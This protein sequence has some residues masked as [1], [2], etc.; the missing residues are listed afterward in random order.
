MKFDYERLINWYKSQYGVP[1]NK[2]VATTDLSEEN[3]TPLRVESPSKQACD[4]LNHF[5]VIVRGGMHQ[6]IE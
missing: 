6:P 1:D 4:Q 5:P 3:S 2:K